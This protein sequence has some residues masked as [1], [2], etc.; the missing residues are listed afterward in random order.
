MKKISLLWIIVIASLVLLP[1]VYSVSC[2]MSQTSC[3]ATCP[4]YNSQYMSNSNGLTGNDGCCGDD[5]TL[6]MFDPF[7]NNIYGWT[8]PSNMVIG[9]GTLSAAQSTTTQYSS[10]IV[11]VTLNSTRSL[12]IS[13]NTTITDGLGYT[14]VYMLDQNKN[15]LYP[16]SGDLNVDCGV[17]Y[18]SGHPP[19]VFLS[20]CQPGVTGASCPDGTHAKCE[21]RVLNS[22]LKIYYLNITLSSSPYGSLNYD[23]FG[24]REGPIFSIPA[25]ERDEFYVSPDNKYTCNFTV[26]EDNRLGYF[27]RGWCGN[28]EIDTNI[29]E[30]CDDGAINGNP[31]VPAYGGTCTYCSG[32]CN[33]ITVAAGFC[34]DGIC[35]SPEET[36]TN[37][38]FDCENGI[39]GWHTTDNGWSLNEENRLVGAA[40]TTDINI[41]SDPFDVRV[42]RNH[43]LEAEILESCPGV[44][45][46]LNDGK[47]LSRN[48][49]T[50]QNC[51]TDQQLSSTGQTTFLLT[52]NNNNHVS[53]GFLKNVSVRIYVPA[54]CIAKFDNIKFKE[55]SPLNPPHIDQPPINLTTACCPQEYCWDGSQCVL[56]DAWNVS[57]NA[58]LW[59]GSTQLMG[60]IYQ[61]VN[62]SR[63]WLAKGYRCTLNETGYADWEAA[64]I[65]YDWNYKY[66]G[67]CRSDSDCFVSHTYPGEG[68]SGCIHDGQFMNN[69]YE[70]N[71]GNHYCLNGE[72]TTKTFLIANVLENLT[73]GD[74]YILFCDDTG[75]IFNNLE[76]T[77]NGNQ[78]TPNNISG[79]CV[80]ISKEG[81]EERIITGFY[82]ATPFEEDMMCQWYVTFYN[83]IHSDFPIALQDCPIPGEDSGCEPFDNGFIR[84]WQEDDFNLYK[85]NESLYY[86]ISKDP[87]SEIEQ[88]FFYNLW[89]NIVGFFQWL[90]GYTPSQPLG[91]AAQTQNYEKLYVLSNNTLKV[92]AV[93]EQK[94]D[95]SLV[96]DMV[97]MYLNMTGSGMNDPNNKF[98][99][100]FVNKSTNGV[101]YTFDESE[102]SRVLVIK[103]DNPAG[104]WPYLTGMLRD[105]P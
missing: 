78:Q 20:A 71:K 76:S 94:Y 32:I 26:E 39:P 47:C 1:G 100:E 13:F 56:S 50:E 8:L 17:D 24:I 33:I 87:I 19:F 55:V 38:I 67:Y 80:L 5:K 11:P 28:E 62:T 74:P 36:S 105:R 83:N 96:R 84:C 46:D 30:E 37:C 89:N 99:I 43:T 88:G 85:N 66:S 42:G 7:D 93:E 58:N 6:F 104:L 75:R 97:Y 91:L 64:E 12:T 95:E 65:K 49:W 72:W 70:L 81:S 45:V 41:Y 61:H 2:D 16:V 79:G 73:D 3:Q 9:G 77:Q 48:G 92:S 57:G 25:A 4:D 21:I 14:R 98:N 29:G 31:C 68:L 44:V 34:G 10:V 69:D 82:V 102:T 90:F 40:T 27:W 35:Q 86:I 15:A 60:Q 103:Y 18:T 23:Y 63:Q 54:G 59:D 22:N 51:F 101:Y 53:Q 52:A